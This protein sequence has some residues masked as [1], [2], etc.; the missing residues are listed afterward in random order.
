MLKYKFRGKV[1]MTEEDLEIYCIPNQQ[2]WVKGNLIVVGE[3]YY[4]TGDVI[5][6]S[7]D[8]II[9]EWWAKVS[10]ESVGQYT[11]VVTGDGIKVYA[12]DVFHLGDSNILY[13]VVW[14]DSGYIGKQNKSSSYVGLRVWKDD[15]E[16]IGKEY[17][18]EDENK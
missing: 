7:E 2:G 4:I 5:E 13:T 15:I 1:V 10:R 12:G 17:D 8:G 16:V 14:N 3:D 18:F 11:G 6:V 9:H